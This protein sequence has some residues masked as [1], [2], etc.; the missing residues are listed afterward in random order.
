[1]ANYQFTEVPNNDEGRAFVK[2]LKQ[3]LNT[4]VYTVRVR[5]QHLKDGLDWR[6]YQYGQPI[7]CSKNLRIYINRRQHNV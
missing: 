4:E 2:Q 1:V 6:D 5:G 7:S 3:Y